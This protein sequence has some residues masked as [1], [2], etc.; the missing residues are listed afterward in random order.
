MARKI[1]KLAIL[2]RIPEEIHSASVINW[3]FI[4]DKKVP[5]D[6]DGFPI[7]DVNYDPT[8]TSL[9]KAVKAIERKVADGVGYPIVNSGHCVLD[10]DHCVDDGIIDSWAMEIIRQCDSYTE[11]SP[12]GTGLHILMSGSPS[13]GDR[14]QVAMGAGHMDVFATKGYVTLTGRPVPGYGKKSLRD[15]AA[16]I[17]RIYSALKQL[18]PAIKAIRRNKKAKRLFAGDTSGY[19]SA[20]EADLAFVSIIAPLVHN[21]RTLVMKLIRQSGLYRKK[22][23]RKDY[24]RRTID[25]VICPD[26]T[27]ELV[28]ELKRLARP[29]SDFLRQDFPPPEWVVDGF[30]AKGTINMVFGPAGVGKSHFL[31]SLLRCLDQGKK[32]MYWRVPTPRRVALID[33]EMPERLI[34]KRLKDWFGASEPDQSLILSSALFRT[35]IDAHFKLDNEHHQRLL[36]ELIVAEDIQVV[37]ID[38]LAPALDCDENSNNDVGLYMPFLTELR[39]EGITVILSH[40]SGKS[41]ESGQR[42]ASRRRDYLDLNLRLVNA[43]TTR[44]ARFTSHFD[45]VREETPE[46]LTWTSEL[47]WDEALFWNLSSNLPQNDERLMSVMQYLYEHRG[48]LVVSQMAEELGI[49]RTRCYAI[50]K[51]A[52]LHGLMDEDEK[53]LTPKGIRLV[54]DR[55]EGADQ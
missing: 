19:A 33:T 2:M 4:D 15:G 13:C 6:Q 7:S 9:D 40:H 27:A 12:S 49:Q 34:Q 37:I 39:D 28:E 46:P 3:K 5:V 1:D 52:L 26:R 53:A 16:I 43:K 35:V 55:L 18:S 42:G 22:W 36:K 38:P 8:S 50:F 30:I 14:R 31:Y 32:F 11:F 24:Q 23:E 41:E 20:S 17:D 45:K 51:R 21:D 44:N 54:D 47:M 29:I 10:L 48:K 25:K